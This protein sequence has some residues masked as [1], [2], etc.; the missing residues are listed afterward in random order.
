MTHSQML[1]GTGLNGEEFHPSHPAISW[2]LLGHK[3]TPAASSPGPTQAPNPQTCAARPCPLNRAAQSS[4]PDPQAGLP[5]T[6]QRSNCWASLLASAFFIKTVLSVQHALRRGIFAPR[7]G[8]SWSLRRQ[9]R[10]SGTHPPA[11]PPPGTVAPA[12]VA[13]LTGDQGALPAV[14]SGGHTQPH[15]L[16]KACGSRAAPGGGQPCWSHRVPGGSF[17]PRQSVWP[18]S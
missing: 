16:R 9:A 13:I 17:W 1:K 18:Q 6:F 12:Q 8:W 2:W 10:R 15:P 14:F 7:A 4:D 3:L 5:R 11:P